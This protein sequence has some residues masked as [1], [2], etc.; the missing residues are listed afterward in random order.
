MAA[1]PDTGP[2][3][4]RSELEVLVAEILGQARSRGA[5]QAEAGA[6]IDTGLS[7]TVRMREVETLEYQRDHGLGV[8]VYFGTRKGSASTSDLSV[9]AVRATVEKACSIARHT[10]EDECA[11]LAD[12][13]LMATEIHDLDLCHPWVLTP[14][15]AIELATACEAA[16]LGLDS[17]IDNS[18]G[19]TVA[20]HQGVRVYANSH[21]F[22][23]GYAATGHTVSCAVLGRDG[24]A[25]QRDYWYTTARDAADLEAVE[26]VGR[27]AAARTLARLG[28]SKMSTRRAPVLYPAELARGLVASFLGAVNGAAQYRRSSFLLD[29][30]GERVFPDFVHM[31]ERPHLLKAMGSAAFD[32]EGVATRDR[33]LVLDGVLQGYV[34]SSYSAR[35]LGLQTT[36]NAGGVHNLVV[37]GGEEDFDALVSRMDCGLLLAEV[38]GQGVNPVTGD[39]S[40][41]ATGFWVEGGQVQFPVHEITIA[42]NLREMYSDIVAIGADVD[43]RGVVCTGSILVGEMTIAGE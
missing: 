41:G 37:A 9:A 25:M 16:A 30:L 26:E 24:E 31:H 38:M 18:E 17:R 10:A 33:D 1:Q 43:T 5:S 13:E 22:V 11:G 2:T 34:L 7:A 27:K 14:D 28:A 40:R 20:T 6:S 32:N 36:G 29:A 15:G 19:A 3:A 12:A 35:K 8:T 21:G 4:E 42:G 39:Y 23:G